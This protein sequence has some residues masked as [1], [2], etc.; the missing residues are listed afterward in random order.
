[1]YSHETFM[2]RC[3]RL[4]VLGAGNVAP[5]P[6]VGAVLVHDDKIIGEGY[7]KQYGGPHAEV[8][9]INSV[10]VADKQLIKYST[11][12]VSLEPCAHFGKTP[13]CANL[14]VENKIPKVV[15]ACKDVN[16][17]VAG[18]GI[19]LLQKNGVEV[20]FGILEQEAQELNKRFFTYHSTKR[21]YIILKWAMYDNDV[22]AGISG[23]QIKI[24]NLFTDKL[25]HK[26][27]TEEA[28][29]LI[30]KNTALNDNP[31]L[32][33]RYWYGKNPVRILFDKNLSV[34]NMANLF[35]NDS[36]VIV[37]NCFSQATH[38]NIYHVKIS[39]ADN[40]GFL[41]ESLHY[42]HA[43]N[44]LSVLVEGGAETLKIFIDNGLWDE[45]RVIVSNDDSVGSGLLAPKIDKT[46]L[47]S[48]QLMLNDIIYYYKKL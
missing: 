45:A 2:Q 36:T 27:R 11:L 34:N 43:Q 26:W 38:H 15:I 18:K 8:N 28:S 37:F 33:S 12:Y 3:L 47:R 14:I 30:G 31:L 24:S 48:K 6:M 41:K 20:V 35:K 17:L 10:S 42:L 23:E 21:P 4:A 1:M 46:F 32:T 16:E 22:M 9:C 7:H 44:I 25:V 5:N 19:D 40:A 13:P 39:A 29:I